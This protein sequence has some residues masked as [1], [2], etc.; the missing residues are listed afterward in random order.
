MFK[1]RLKMTAFL[2]KTN[3]ISK[4]KKTQ[5]LHFYSRKERSQTV[6]KG[7]NYLPPA[8]NILKADIITWFTP[9]TEISALAMRSLTLQVTSFLA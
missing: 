9:D 8:I 4:T 1:M 5:G 2:K 6:S 3:P 7:K